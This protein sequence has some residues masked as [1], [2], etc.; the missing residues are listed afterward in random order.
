MNNSKAEN[1]IGKRFYQ[2]L[3]LILI[4]VVLFLRIVP[5]LKMAVTWD[6]LGTLY[7]VGYSYSFLWEYILIG[8]HPPLYFFVMKFLTE[9]F[10]TTHMLLKIP[11][12]LASFALIYAFY[13]FT[14]DK[15]GTYVGYVI[16]FLFSISLPIFLFGFE[17]RP[18][19]FII[20][21][22]FL[23][24]IYYQ[25][26]FDVMLVEK[27]ELTRLECLKLFVIGFTCLYT[28]YLSGLFFICN[29]INWGF[30]II[31][32]QLISGHQWFFHKFV[33]TI[34]VIAISYLPWF[35]LTYYKIS[36]QL[37]EYPSG[38]FNYLY[39]FQS[40]FN[41]SWGM[42]VSFVISFFFTIYSLFKNQTAESL[43]FKL[44][45]VTYF[46]FV[47]IIIV[48]SLMFSSLISLRYL[49]IL[50]PFLYLIFGYTLKEIFQNRKEVLLSLF[51]FLPLMYLS[52][53][54]EI[55]KGYYQTYFIDFPKIFNRMETLSSEKI[56]LKSIEKTLLIAFFGNH[57][58]LEYPIENHT[59]VSKMPLFQL[60]Q[61]PWYYYGGFCNKLKGDRQRLLDQISQDDIKGIWLIFPDGECDDG[62]NLRSEL[63][64]LAKSVYRENDISSDVGIEY[65]EVE[66][67]K[68]IMP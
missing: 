11:S 3:L 1:T 67:N 9:F 53:V 28:S 16:T 51:L 47:F 30:Y 63:S 29:T 50:T 31:W 40:F 55:G 36:Q 38:F 41:H 27:R 60:H 14:R 10:T 37:Y 2:I 68:Q 21:F 64:K 66:S 65:W 25:K 44:I 42:S 5:Y 4:C 45:F 46:I 62:V 20:L 59:F 23:S 15:L 12:T 18:Y 54:S 6:E 26:I 22:S 52:P 8:K 34:C 43:K 13:L 33:K 49:A 32:Q 24:V 7:E 56:K 39:I 48:R 19:L 17:G 35:L 57:H 61:K 58:F